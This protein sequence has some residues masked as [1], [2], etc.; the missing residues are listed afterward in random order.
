MFHLSPSEILFFLWYDKK[1]TFD[2]PEGIVSPDPVTY[3]IEWLG[4]DNFSHSWMSPGGA[5]RPPELHSLEF[6]M[7]FIHEHAKYFKDPLEFGTC[8]ADSTAP[9]LE[10]PNGAVASGQRHILVSNLAAQN[11]RF[12]FL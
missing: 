10:A 12:Y 2:L 4:E 3:T 9:F 6:T 1:V 8:E 7:H 11:H 5:D